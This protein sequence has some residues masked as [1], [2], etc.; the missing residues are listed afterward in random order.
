MT[1]RLAY[2]RV[3]P[4]FEQ[5]KFN[6]KHANDSDGRLQHAKVRA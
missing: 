4:E 3:G 5:N 2:A 6:L 1:R